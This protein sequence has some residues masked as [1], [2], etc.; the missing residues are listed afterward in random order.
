MIYSADAVARNSSLGDINT[1]K[2]IEMHY[3]D[4]V[5]IARR[6]VDAKELLR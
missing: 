1:T 6:I 5:L 2:H 3:L 4:L